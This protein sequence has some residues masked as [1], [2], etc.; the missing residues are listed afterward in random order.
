MDLL[1]SLEFSNLDTSLITN[2]ECIF[3]DSANK[4]AQKLEQGF[5]DLEDDTVGIIINIEGQKIAAFLTCGS[6]S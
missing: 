6:K 4:I 1:T 5:Y 2:V 3:N